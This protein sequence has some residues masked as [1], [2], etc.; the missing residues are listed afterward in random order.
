MKRRDV[1]VIGAAICIVLLAFLL[2]QLAQKGTPNGEIRIY[3]HNTLR[4]TASL[5]NEQTIEIAGENGALNIIQIKD[6]HVCMQFSSCKNQL[7]VAQGMLDAGNYGKRAMGNSII[8]LPHGVVVELVLTEP[9]NTN[10][11][12]V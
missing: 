9:T 5:Y 3:Q 4:Q 12:D 6:G 2:A 8:C 10:L 7:C 1:W 11:P